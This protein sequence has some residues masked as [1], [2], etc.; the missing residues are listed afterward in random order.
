VATR[1]GAKVYRVGL[2]GGQVVEEL[3]EP[4]LIA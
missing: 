1:P 2:V 3:M 4:E